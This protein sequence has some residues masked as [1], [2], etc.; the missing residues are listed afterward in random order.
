[1]DIIVTSTSTFSSSLFLSFIAPCSLLPLALVPLL[2]TLLLLLLLFSLFSV[3][4]G[5]PPPYD[6]ERER[7]RE[8][9]RE[10]ESVC[11]WE[12]REF[13][14]Q[15]EGECVW[16]RE[17]ECVCECVCVWQREKTNSTEEK[18][19]STPIN[20][21]QHILTTKW[22]TN[23]NL[24]HYS[25]LYLFHWN[26]L[27][28]RTGCLRTIWNVDHT[29]ERGSVKLIRLYVRRGYLYVSV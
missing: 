6:P 20:S 5:V 26:W 17:C 14:C 11:V 18:S 4:L 8:R 19:W 27:E 22:H 3:L 29:P 24:I 9:E 23:T 16:E 1:M 12:K 2:R 28:V 13:V 10:K 7:E 25:Q 15:R 21:I